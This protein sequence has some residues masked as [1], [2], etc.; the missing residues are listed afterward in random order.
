MTG[1]KRVVVAMQHAA[2]VQDRHSGRFETQ[3][4]LLDATQRYPLAKV[5]NRMD[6]LPFL[7]VE[8]NK[9]FAP[10]VITTTDEVRKMGQRHQLVSAGLATIFSAVMVIA[11]HLFTEARSAKHLVTGSAALVRLEMSRQG[12]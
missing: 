2:K 3:C 11:S 5:R 10:V 1:A 9:L 8:R 4:E 6:E 12:F 7:P